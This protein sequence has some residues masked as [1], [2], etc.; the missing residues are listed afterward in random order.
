MEDPLRGPHE[1]PDPYA[2]RR[3]RDCPLDREVRRHCRDWAL[4]LASGLEA[5][6]T[7]ATIAEETISQLTKAQKK[8]QC[9]CK[10]IIKATLVTSTYTHK[11]RKAR[12]AKDS[13]TKRKKKRAATKSTAT[14]GP[15]QNRTTAPNKRK[16]TLQGSSGGSKRSR[17]PL[18][19]LTGAFRGLGFVSLA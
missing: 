5:A 1:A 6:L 3:T 16:A 9:N 10:Q 19:S 14:T 13:A 18:R 11:L 7:R 12:I 2:C 8:S 4:Q 15:A 17:Q